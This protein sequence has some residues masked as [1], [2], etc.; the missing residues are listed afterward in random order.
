MGWH[1]FLASIIYLRNKP[2]LY[3]FNIKLILLLG[4]INPVYILL[5]ISL[6]I[7]FSHTSPAFIYFCSGLFVVF[8]FFSWAG[9]LSCGQNKS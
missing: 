8:V 4:L 3:F 9:P 6:L 2:L 5:F 1:L 7:L